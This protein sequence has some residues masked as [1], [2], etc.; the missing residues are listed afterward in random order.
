M[1]SFLNSCFGIDVNISE[2]SYES[3]LQWKLKKTKN[4][5]NECSRFVNLLQPILA[6]HFTVESMSAEIQ[7]DLELDFMRVEK[8]FPKFTPMFDE[9]YTWFH[10]TRY[11][12]ASQLI[13]LNFLF[14]TLCPPMSMR[15]LRLISRV[16][17][18]LKVNRKLIDAI[19]NLPELN[20]L[21]RIPSAQIPYVSSQSPKLIK[22]SIWAL[23]AL[24]DDFFMKRALKKQNPFVRQQF[25]KWHN[26]TKEY[27]R[28]K[29]QSI[30]Q[31]W[32]SGEW[33]KEE[34]FVNIVKSRGGMSSWPHLNS[35]IAIP[36][37]VSILL[38]LCEV[39][40]N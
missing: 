39:D 40:I 2:S 14:R 13:L 34:R 25:I 29:T 32:F 11:G 9:L 10:Y 19:I 35:D 38:D 4:I 28:K 36:A 7:K 1:K 30:V 27:G 15:F 5:L 22:E 24:L 18:R 6:T 23:R 31:E 17:P 37:N 26:L 20:H 3:F 33:I 12:M 21:N 16:H 8:N